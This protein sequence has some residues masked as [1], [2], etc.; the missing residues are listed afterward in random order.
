MSISITSTTGSAADLDAAATMYE[1]D[2]LVI[3]AEPTPADKRGDDNDQGHE[4]A[5]ARTENVAA[6]DSTKS[7]EEAQRDTE[8][9]Q[10][11]ID[12]TKEE[13]A[14]EYLGRPMGKTRAKL[15]RRLSRLH[16]ENESLR[17]QLATQQGPQ[18]A[19]PQNGNGPQPRQDEQQQ[20]P[21]NQGQLRWEA[22]RI[23]AEI[24]YPYKV[25]AAKQ[26]YP[27]FEQSLNAAKNEV[28]LWTLDAMRMMPNGA[29]M[30]YWFAKNPSYADKLLELDRAGQGRKPSSF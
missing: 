5:I 4:A 9:V 18:P 14:E 21:Q 13:R 26:K 7:A 10:R 17:E 24:A 27:D 15:L 19:Q 8:E 23:E 22:A 3:P 11:N 2:E 16:S 29:D 30:A 20:P 1:G 28:P 12:E 6:F 25:E